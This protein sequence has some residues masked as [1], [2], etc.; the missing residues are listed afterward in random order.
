MRQVD[1]SRDLMS[2]NALPAN[3]SNP[4]DPIPKSHLPFPVVGIGASAGGMQ[5][6]LRFF[7]NAPARMDMAFVVVL[8]LSPNH[9]SNADR[10]LQGMTRMRVLQVDEAVPIQKNHVYVIAPGK[11]LA[12]TDGYLRVSDRERTV[13]APV[14]IDNFFRTLAS[15]HGAHA[16][17][18][19]FSG[20][21]SD[22]SVG[23]S[24][25]K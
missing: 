22:G 15:A 9:V 25:V 21:G 12:M 10:V 3:T 17:A 4:A 5:A 13:G 24:R 7:E 2:D 11:T 8:H 18:M 20:T 14:T 23:I 1:I 19:V 16:I 6:L